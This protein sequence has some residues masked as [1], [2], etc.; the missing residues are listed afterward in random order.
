MESPIFAA[1]AGLIGLT[2]G[3]AIVRQGAVY[4][5]NALKRRM[6]VSLE[7]PSKDQSYTWLLEWLSKHKSTGRKSLIDRFVSDKHHQ[8]AVETTF[9]RNPNG[10][11]ASTFTF[12]PGPGMHFFK[13]KNA[14]FK[15][16]R[17]R[18]RT[19]I[20]LKSGT[21]W[22]TLTITGLSRDRELLHE[23]LQESKEMALLREIGK[24]VV[25]T[26][27]GPDWRPFGNPRGKR[28]LESVILDSNTFDILKDI[29]TFLKSES[30]YHA[31]GIPYRRGYLLHGPPGSGKTSLI[32]AIAGSLD[33]NICLLN[34][35]ER[36]MTDDRLAHLMNNVPSNSLIL[37]E[38]VDAAFPDRNKLEAQKGHSS[39][40]FSGLLNAL[41]GVAASEERIIFMTTNYL[42]RL[43]SAL[44]RPGR[45]DIQ[46]FVGNATR[47]QALSLF[48]HFY[49]DEQLG[50]EFVTNLEK[51]NLIGTLS[52]ARLQGHFIKH[53]DDPFAASLAINV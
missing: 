30:W 33:Y 8:L 37:L 43:D 22:E 52:P 17:H 25:F 5:T 27:Y 9:K 7:I 49:G 29:K 36:G 6:L 26:S 31:R 44:T 42:D 11:V 1:G 35:S 48:T 21:P 10:S 39:M 20:D 47:N 19:M 3:L 45:V 51:Q 23:I 38:D 24:T 13:Y 16:E 14:W 18:E 50:I 2:A 34:L 12:V 32:Q 4:G 15:V 41:D 46:M 53:R 40:T 28:P